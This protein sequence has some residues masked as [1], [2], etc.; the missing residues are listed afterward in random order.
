MTIPGAWLN[1]NS[2][3]L[4]TKSD[5]L[6]TEPGT[7][8]SLTIL[9]P[10]Y[11]E[12][13]IATIKPTIEQALTAIAKY[14]HNTNAPANI[15]IADDSVMLDQ[16][17]NPL[18]TARLEYYHSNNDTILV[19]ARPAKGRRGKFKKAGNVNFAL[20]THR[21]AIGD[22]IL[23]IDSD[24]RL[25]IDTLHLVLQEFIDPRVAL[26]QTITKSMIDPTQTKSVWV[27][28]VAHFT[29]N[30]Y[31]LSFRLI[32]AFGDPSPFVGHNAFIRY[33]SLQEVA[34][35]SYK[36]TYQVCEISENV[37]QYS[38]PQTQLI[39]EYFSE[40]HVSEDFELSTRLQAANYIISYCTYMHG[41]EEGVTFTPTD[42]IIRLNK[43]A[44]GVSELL[45]NPIREWRS[46]GILSQTIKAFLFSP[47][48]TMTTKYN[49]LGYTGTYYALAVA[50]AFC[51][52]HYFAY[53]YSEV[54][55]T[56]VINAEHV[57][58]S[59]MCVF[60]ILTPLATI[61]LKWKLGLKLRILK[62]FRY[63]ILFGIFFAGIGWHL[64][65][66]LATHFFS[67]DTGWGSTNKTT[68]TRK[69]IR[70]QI[71]RLWPVL[72]LSA[73]ELTIIPLGWFFLD[74]RAW[75]AIVPLAI[76]ASSHILVPFLGFL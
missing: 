37:L 46:K 9:I 66:A 10:V 73:A 30:I 47:N 61:I 52:A 33:T 57:L 59:C 38:P 55:R 23:I 20:S 21:E 62:E 22:I 36:Q 71:L 8:P 65:T 70:K 56:T 2:R 19:S 74:L 50:P 64:L 35:P 49:I 7:L 4:A 51:I 13:F 67:I 41:F 29:D 15:L 68:P 1:T 69:E 45:I 34:H 48:I 5:S 75:P 24:T 58:Y 54:W 27:G 6:Y 3:Y 42:E 17:D 43:Y 14:T 28:A 40:E 76:S 60:S 53:H 25:P 63:S 18:I 26:V 44:Y 16:S 12:D 31:Q 72:L 11:K 32:T 39:T